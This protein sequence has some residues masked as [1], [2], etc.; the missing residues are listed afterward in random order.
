MNV[1]LSVAVMAH[2]ARTQHAW[3]LAR[4]LAAPVIWDRGAGEWDT[5][6][7]AWAAFDPDAT[8]H[9][10]V[11]DDAIPV[12]GFLEHATAAITA[13]PISPISFYL[14]RSRPPGMQRRIMQ[15]TLAADQ[16]KLAW[17]RLRD[18]LHGV[19]IA[20]P[21]ADVLPMLD[22]AASSRRPYDERLGAWYRR[23]GTVVQYTWPSLVDHADGPTLVAHHDRQPRTGGRVAWRHGTPDTW[24]TA[25]LGI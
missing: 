15:A 8:H 7:R 20:L 2:P 1:R 22:W 14:G 17:L 16:Q 9:V 4:E 24:E 3:W 6:A 19:A 21:T 23:L 5:A 13:R 18:M 25:S 11:Q 12:P 10:V